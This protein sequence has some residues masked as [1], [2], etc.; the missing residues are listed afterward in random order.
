MDSVL[1]EIEDILFQYIARY[2]DKTERKEIWNGAD[3][4]KALSMDAEE[5]IKDQLWYLVKAELNY[6]RI[7]DKVKDDLATMT[8]SEKEENESESEDEEND[9]HST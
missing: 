1:S 4:L 5:E 9:A 8:D 7:V 6:Q 3:C 2:C